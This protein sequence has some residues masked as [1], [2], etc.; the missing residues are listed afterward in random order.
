M[1][2]GTQQSRAAAQHG[3]G[4]C[5]ERRAA[6]E[7]LI[8]ELP[9][10]TRSKSH[11]PP[12]N[13]RTA[14]GAA[15]LFGRAARASG[16]RAAGGALQQPGGGR[17]RVRHKPAVLGTRG[18]M[19]GQ[20]GS[21]LLVAGGAAAETTAAARRRRRRPGGGG[22]GGAPLRPTAEIGAER[23]QAPVIIICSI[24]D[25][26]LAQPMRRRGND[27]LAISQGVPT[28]RAASSCM[29]VNAL[30]AV[31][32]SASTLATAAAL[33]RPLVPPCR[34]SAMPGPPFQTTKRSQATEG[35]APTMR[36]EGRRSGGARCRGG[37]ERAPAVAESRVA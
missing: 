15:H 4:S 11:Q 5:R 21:R 26:Q 31:G 27:R 28:G 16:Q 32:R 12:T 18:W 34:G 9:I 37:G 24:R 10:K 3:W 30:R 20:S 17:V 1:G 2:V 13:S 29:I 6:A 8:A 14:A 36:Q 25:P 33:A 7:L 22:G 35:A 23:G 19:F